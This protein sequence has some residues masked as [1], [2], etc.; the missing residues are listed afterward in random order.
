MIVCLIINQNASTNSYGK[1]IDVSTH[2]ASCFLL[3]DKEHR[4]IYLS[5]RSMCIA[6]T[7]SIKFNLD[8][9]RRRLNWLNANNES[10]K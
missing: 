7:F 10:H 8:E 6:P 2:N 3:I 5:I 4:Y 1:D 9:K